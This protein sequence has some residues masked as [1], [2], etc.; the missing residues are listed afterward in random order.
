MTMNRSVR[1]RSHLPTLSPNAIP[2]RKRLRWSQVTLLPGIEWRL[3]RLRT[4]AMSG[5]GCRP[6]GP[7]RGT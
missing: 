2:P 3:C 4:E 1:L 5:S 7:S 6:L